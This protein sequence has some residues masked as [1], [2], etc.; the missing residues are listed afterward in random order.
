MEI[1]STIIKKLFANA[2]SEIVAAVIGATVLAGGGGIYGL[3]RV[4]KGAN[5]KDKATRQVTTTIEGIRNLKSLTPASY[6]EDMV[7]IGKKKDLKETADGK[8][9]G[10]IVIVQRAEVRS[11]INLDGLKEEDIRFEGDS[12]VFITL[13]KPSLTVF[14]D[15]NKHEVFEESGSWSLEQIKE[16]VEPYKKTVE[17]KAIKNGILDMANASAE[18]LVDEFFISSG[19]KVIYNH[20]SLPAPA[21]EQ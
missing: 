14:M 19:Y 8:K 2:S 18:A 10:E 4:I 16:V 17:E 21:A 3:S 12:V 11:G 6:F 1:F 7:I 5:D 9:R 13:P 15:V 20:P